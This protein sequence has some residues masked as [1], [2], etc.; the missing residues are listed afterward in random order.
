M[1]RHKQI[2]IMIEDLGASQLSLYIMK[3]INQKL[4]SNDTDVFYLTCNKSV[5]CINE[6]KAAIFSIFYSQ[7]IDATLVATSSYTAK[8]LKTCLASQERIFYITDLDWVR[9]QDKELEEEI[10]E[11]LLD[12]GIIK[13]CRSKE[14]FDFIMKNYQ[15]NKI[16]NT[17]VA[18]FEINKIMEIINGF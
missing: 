7:N 18:N 8:I 4:M 3:D 9:K 16:S 13:L 14:Y 2:G 17:I 11:I 12:D 6:N 15:V 10:K 5:P 1:S